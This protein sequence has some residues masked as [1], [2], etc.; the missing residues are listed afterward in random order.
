MRI[1][2]EQDFITATSE[3]GTNFSHANMQN[4][5]VDLYFE[6]FYSNLLSMP[7]ERIRAVPPACIFTCIQTRNI[8]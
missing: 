6:N 7:P 5:Y 3:G 2:P 1:C 4:A 8:L